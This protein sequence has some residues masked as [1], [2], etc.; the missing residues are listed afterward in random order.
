MKKLVEYVIIRKSFIFGNNLLFHD[1]TFV[2]DCTIM[3]T[4]YFSIYFE[5]FSSTYNWS[6]L[7]LITVRL[8]AYAVIFVTDIP[9][10]PF[11]SVIFFIFSFSKIHIYFNRLQHF[12]DSIRSSCVSQSVLNVAN[13]N[14]KNI[15]LDQ[16]TY[17][18]FFRFFVFFIYLFFQRTWHEA[19]NSRKRIVGTFYLWTQFNKYLFPD[20][21]QPVDIKSFCV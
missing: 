17:E 19:V 6:V 7:R 3:S 1:T 2:S 18:N 13:K 20:T 11:S 4:I 12:Y 14:E 5:I 9:F 21:K 16:R 10:I 8:I 15:L